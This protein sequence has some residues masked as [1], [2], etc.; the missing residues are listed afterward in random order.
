MKILD[1][2]IC[3]GDDSIRLP[4]TTSSEYIS[5]EL[6]PVLIYEEIPQYPPECKEKKIGARVVV[7][8]YVDSSG[9]V[10]RACVTRSS[11]PGF[12]FEQ[13]AAKAALRHVYKPV[14]IDKKPIGRWI[15]YEVSFI[16]GP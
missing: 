5:M 11:N 3:V 12:G 6:Y 1:P 14:I 10:P 4:D 7:W 13:A 2:P 15:D 9:K 8:A 16:P